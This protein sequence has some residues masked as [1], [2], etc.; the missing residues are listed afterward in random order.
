M[1]N[2]LK[3][4]LFCMIAGIGI[5]LL[6]DQLKLSQP[7]SSSSESTTLTDSAVSST[8]WDQSENQVNAPSETEADAPAVA[9]KVEVLE[10]ILKSKN[11][12][13]PRLDTE[14][15]TLSK[16]LKLA[17]ARKYN[18]LKAESLNERGT[19]VFLLGRNLKSSQDF[20]FI[21]KVLSEHPCQSLNDCQKIPE[22]SDPDEEGV[23]EITLVYPQIVALKSIETYLK[24]NP[25]SDQAISL[26][27]IASEAKN[28]T[29]RKIAFA[30]LNRS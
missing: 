20:A 11:D 12:N 2:H 23:N 22:S 18:E 7:E 14:F 5:G 9:A 6:K 8:V 10:E 15:K 17:L 3:V 21:K 16:P 19:I 1:K 25:N 29:I 26:L 13:D 30:I 24:K 4:L 28:D 27:K